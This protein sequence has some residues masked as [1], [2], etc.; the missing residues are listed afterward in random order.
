M[1]VS[2]PMGQSPDL[3]QSFTV[4]E[5]DPTIIRRAQGVVAARL[6]D[7]EAVAEVLDMLGIRDR[8]Y[9]ITEGTVS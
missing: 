6:G 7:P 5:L 9:P 4:E 2:N 8:Y 3:A 1:T